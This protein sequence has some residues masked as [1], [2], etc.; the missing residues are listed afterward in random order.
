[1]DF[2][3]T[4]MLDLLDPGEFQEMVVGRALLAI[5]QDFLGAYDLAEF[6]P[7]VGI[8]GVEIGMSPLHRLT[9]GGPQTFGIVAR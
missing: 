6:L 2:S 9:E 1:M 7:G 3:G 4:G 5:K 8:T